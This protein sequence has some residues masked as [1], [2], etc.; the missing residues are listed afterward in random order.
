[1]S[2]RRGRGEIDFFD[3][4]IFLNYKCRRERNEKSKYKKKLTSTGKSFKTQEQLKVLIS[5]TI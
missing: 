3:T 1:M 2:N 5:L 4:V